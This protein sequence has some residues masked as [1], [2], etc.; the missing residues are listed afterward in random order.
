MLARKPVRRPKRSKPSATQS[1]SELQA[2]LPVHVSSQVAFERFLEEGKLVVVD[3]W[4]P[5]CAPCRAMGPIF[6]K[7][8]K[9]FAGRVTF[10]KVNTEEVPEVAQAFGI[11][12]IPTLIVLQGQE[13][14]NSQV[15]LISEAGLGQ[16]VGR[17]LDRS[18]GITLTDRIKR[19]FGRDEV[20]ERAL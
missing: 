10:V 13:V 20:G 14:V 6:E 5:W 9:D 2:G 15:G 19:L 17:A 3:F 16:M 11:R 18:Q 7:V 12:S 1:A 4:A 8:A